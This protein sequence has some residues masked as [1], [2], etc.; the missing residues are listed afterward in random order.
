MFELPDP[1]FISAAYLQVLG[2]APD[3]KGLIQYQRALEHGLSR[4][5]LVL[6][7]QRSRESGQADRHR[8]DTAALLTQL[9]RLW[10]EPLGTELTGLRSTREG[11]LDQ[12]PD[13]LLAEAAFVSR[14][15]R[16]W[17]P[18]EQRQWVESL[19]AG[20]RG[21]VLAA[22]RRLGW[23]RPRC[24][25]PR[26]PA[27]W[28]R[29]RWPGP[30]EPGL[31]PSPAAR[32]AESPRPGHLGPVQWQPRSTVAF[33]IAT[34]SYHAFA[35]RLMRSAGQHHPAWSRVV[36]QVD[37]ELP[38]HVDA[39]G[40]LHVPA[41]ALGVPAFADMRVRYDVVELSTAL[42]PFVFQWLLQHAGVQRAV[43]LDPDILVLQ[44]MVPV[45]QALDAGHAVVLTPHI[46]AP[47]A[48]DREPSE[49]TLLKSGV[50]N[51]G[52]IAIARHPEAEAF[53]A[54]WSRKLRTGALVAL[55]QNLFTDQRWCDFAPAFVPSLHVLRHAGCNLAYWNLA[56]RPL[57]VDGTD[58]P[59]TSDGPV[60]FFH[61]SGFDPEHPEVL[62]KYQNRLTWE[63]IAPL[64]GLL[65]TYA[66]D[67]LEL[68]WQAT[69]R[70]PYRFG[71]IEGLPLPPMVRSWYRTRH[72]E[73]SEGDSVAL[74]DEIASSAGAIPGPA[75]DQAALSDLML[76]V[77]RSDPE[78]RCSFDLDSANGRLALA[79]WF[80]SAGALR[81]DLVDF[82]VESRDRRKGPSR[83]VQR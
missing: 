37:G 3:P 49:H 57:R 12:L 26:R 62:S 42:K 70:T 55:D 79:R 69:R 72:P 36:V 52:F 59:V 31:D 34:C 63:D 38:P 82:L 17:G 29:A 75:G 45:E 68:G 39:A 61:F 53:V 25:L 56:Q 20:G 50:F 48:D 77:H 4:A 18:E 11:Q 19:R 73:P 6:D 71:H 51:L 40:V 78:A 80:W 65:R 24:W 41:Q 2:R 9:T 66:E 58:V 67:L 76:H 13:E 60:V 54:W 83:D 33:T 46:D 21:A 15:E 22:W 8:P 47:L 16:P 74:A 10:P 7:L 81:H 44:P 27:T 32:V 28:W 35:T 23:S 5:A 64:H 1:L 30:A 14:F 43:Y